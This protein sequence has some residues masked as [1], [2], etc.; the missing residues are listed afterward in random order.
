MNN[1]LEKL[2]SICIPAHDEE[3]NISKILDYALS[4]KET[5]I[6]EILVGINGCTDN[7]QAVVEKYAQI[8]SQVKVFISGIGKPNA[9]NTLFK[10]SIHNT[11]VFFD[12]DVHPAPDCL[13]K[14]VDA[15]NSGYII[16][17]GTLRAEIPKKGIAN[18]IVELL[19]KETFFTNYLAGGGYAVNKQKLAKRLKEKGYNEMPKDL[20]AEDGWLQMHL[21]HEEYKRVLDAIV[22]YHPGEFQ[23]Y[24]RHEARLKVAYHQLRESFNDLYPSWIEEFRKERTETTVSNKFQRVYSR[25]AKVEGMQSKGIYLTQQ[26]LRKGVQL[27]YKD[28]INKIYEEMMEHYKNKGGSALLNTLGRLKSSKVES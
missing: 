26:I 4:Q 22:T 6:G 16:A 2:I 11:L 12:A 14:L 24:L 23:D 28:E 13:H 5:P 17:G 21:K 10:N 9:W 20:L 7:T 15:I 8:D 18:R 3:Q 19:K 25:I 1:N 27:F